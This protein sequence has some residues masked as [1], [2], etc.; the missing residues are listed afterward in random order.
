MNVVVQNT[1]RLHSLEIVETLGLTT[2]CQLRA[3]QALVHQVMT[4]ATLLNVPLWAL[5]ITAVL[6]SVSL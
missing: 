3:T 1:Q 2:L 5:G 6:M 4:V